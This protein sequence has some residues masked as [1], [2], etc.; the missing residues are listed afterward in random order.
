MRLL[1]I[2]M[3]AMLPLSTLSLAARPPAVRHVSTAG[4]VWINAAALPS[5][6]SLYDGDTLATADNGFAMISGAGQ[7][8]AEVRQDSLVHISSGEITLKGGAV[9]S[10]GLAVRLGDDRIQ[11]AGPSRE[12]RWFVVADRGGRRL[13]AAYQGDVAIERD[14]AEPVLV[15]QGSFAVPSRTPAD[16]DQDPGSRGG[17]GSIPSGPDS[18]WVIFSLT[19]GVSIALIAALGATATVAAIVG[20]TL[21]E[22]SVSPSN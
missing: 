1:A 15:P 17:G 18:G 13:V 22:R 11:P 9:G 16:A 5:G 10:E 12:Q 8:R 6:S 14:G 7:G 3:A 21:G 19:S 20:Y 2:L 4:T